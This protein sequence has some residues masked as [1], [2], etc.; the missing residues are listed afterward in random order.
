MPPVADPVMRLH[1]S[2]EGDVP[3]DKNKEVEIGQRGG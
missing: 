2:Y 3:G 1:V